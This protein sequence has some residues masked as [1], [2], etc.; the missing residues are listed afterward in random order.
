MARSD[1]RKNGEA[2]ETSNRPNETVPYLK[3]QRYYNWFSGTGWLAQAEQCRRF[4][5]G[6]QYSPNV[7]PDAPKPTMNICREYEEKA[8][9]KLLET[10]CSLEFTAE[11]EDQ[12]LTKLDE[13]YEFQ[14]AKIHNKSKI[15]RVCARAMIDGNGVMVTAFDADEF[16]TNSLYRGFL[17]REVIPFERTYWANPT[18]ENPQDQSYW[19][20]YQ[21]MEIAAVREMLAK[22]YG[23][24]KGKK[25]SKEYREKYA[26]LAPEE[27]IEAGGDIDY[28]S[29]DPKTI[30]VYWRFFRVDGEV[31]FEAATKYCN[32]FKHPHAMSP[33][34]NE[35]ALSHL[36]T[37]QEDVDEE[38]K[39]LKGGPDY[40]V[41]DYEIDSARYTLFE[42]AVRESEE[43]LSGRK[44]KF[45]RY[46]VQ[47]YRPY[48]FDQ[49]ILGL[50][51]VSL[52]IPNQKII[53]LIYFYITLIMQYHAMPKWVVT[54]NA[55]KGQK[56]NNE[57][58]QVITDYSTPA[59]NGG[60][61]GISRL[62]ATD[63]VPANL[64]TLGSE[65]QNETRVTNSFENITGQ[66]NSGDSGFLYQQK[67][68]QAN[69]TL[70]QPQRR[71][72]DFQEE[73][74]ETDLLFFAH[75]VDQ[76]AFTKKLEDGEYDEME[77]ARRQSLSLVNSGNPEFAR[78][79]EE[80]DAMSVPSR[81]VRRISVDSTLFDGDFS[82]S[83]EAVQ[84]LAT[85]VLSEGEEYDSV[86]QAMMAGNVDAAFLRVYIAGN[87][88]MHYKTKQ[89]L[90]KALDAYENSELR[91]KDEEI[92]QLKQMIT[93][94]AGTLQ[95]A[96][97]AIDL[98]NQQNK[99]E[100]DA[101]QE[102][103]KTNLAVMKSF[104]NQQANQESEGQ[105]K[106]QNSRGGRDG[107]GGNNA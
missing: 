35:L 87:R 42:K 76:A 104:T 3:W 49:S 24:G 1:R 33:E 62:S 12:D 101:F 25:G 96:N 64:I 63:A 6:N 17:K 29:I 90:R 99:A 97:Q 66:T 20:Y 15:A 13:F 69:L 81:R 65:M 79:Q 102:Q 88:N 53:N 45:W 4:I 23:V 57:P 74:A 40:E 51:P 22:E 73:V 48:P 106:S 2:E 5:A 59:E 85:S 75:F 67:V 77:N 36:E 83:V 54:P 43:E 27:Q 41:P 95:N 38:E 18:V 34:L 11:R 19:G 7:S 26:L 70:E 61:S 58:N 44:R 82:V 28:G 78:P 21:D 84:G 72:W 93:Q 8:V 9:A 56:P 68:Q 31:A 60:R 55:L 30:R 46:P 71:L 103:N 32:I 92:A 94:L 47:V 89:R 100:R 14:M 86:M 10:E 98:A 39:E 52:L 91:Q 80:V 16:G 105:K 107:I 50:S 37:N